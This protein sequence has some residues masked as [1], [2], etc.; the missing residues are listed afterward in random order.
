MPIL[1]NK[2]KTKYSPSIPAN[3]N[4]VE[5]KG[6]TYEIEVFQGDS[7]DLLEYI[8]FVNG[9]PGNRDLEIWE[10]TLVNA[11]YYTDQFHQTLSVFSCS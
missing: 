1:W 11:A 9:P 10:R 7:V 3:D 2:R 5:Q 8:Q 4:N 6:E